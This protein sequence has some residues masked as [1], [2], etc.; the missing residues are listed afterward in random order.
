MEVGGG[1]II[2]EACHYLD[3]MVFLTGSKITSIC[4]NAIGTNPEDSTDN[5][6][7]LVKFENGSNGVL[8][9]FSNGNKA[10]PKE[11][12]EIHSQNRSM[13]MDNF[14]LTTSF[15]VNGFNKLK[16]TIDKGHNAQFVGIIE[17]LKSDKIQTIPFD[18]ICNVTLASFAAL[19]SLKSNSWITIHS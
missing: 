8:N 6:S 13:I 19:E 5:A 9:Y 16:T 18:E 10:Y 3:L 14:R 2:G 17:S 1:R 4:M 12:L 15:G 11:R 7:I